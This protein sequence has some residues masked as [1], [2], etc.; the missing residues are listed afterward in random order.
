VSTVC[1]LCTESGPFYQRL[2]KA[3]GRT[4]LL[5]VLPQPIDEG[6][7]YLEKLG[8]SVDKIRQV[9]L[10]SIDVRG[11]PTLMLVNSDGVVVNT[12]IGT[13]QVDREAEVLSKMQADRASN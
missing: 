4:Q 6:K 1:H 2:A 7:R 8:V 13:L 11:T 3:R 5:A 12:W 9:S 10:S